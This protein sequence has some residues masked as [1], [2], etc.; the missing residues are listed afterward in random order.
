MVHKLGISAYGE[1]P[2]PKHRVM[3]TE[4][5][6]YTDGLYATN[7]SERN[8]RPSAG[9]NTGS[10]DPKAN[11]GYARGNTP[12]GKIVIT[13][14]KPTIPSCA[15]NQGVSK[16]CFR[17]HMRKI[18]VKMKTNMLRQTIHISP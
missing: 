16:R 2:N 6:E 12:N 11:G 5:D 13:V 1:G 8:S 9:G 4:E 17:L 15:I 18:M 3:L 7:D 14:N 10:K